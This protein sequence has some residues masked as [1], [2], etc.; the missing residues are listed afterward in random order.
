MPD[1]PTF[2]RDIDQPFRFRRQPVSLPADVRPF[3]KIAELLL[4]LRESSRG[5]KSSLKR[6][7][8]LNWAV[9]SEK[10]TAEFVAARRGDLPLFRFN[11][12]FEPAFSRAI[13]LAAGLGLVQWV[14]GDRIQLAAKGSQMADQILSEPGLFD[15]ERQF[16]GEIGKTVT[17]NEADRLLRARGGS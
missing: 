3:W 8:L 16:L 13:D 15:D 2:S 11:V 17:E 10:Y 12:R 5:G 4:L 7:H 6:L 14:G 1:R 9:R